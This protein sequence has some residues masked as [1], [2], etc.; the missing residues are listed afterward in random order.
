MKKQPIYLIL[1]AIFLV[2]IFIIFVNIYY[3]TLKKTIAIFGSVSKEI[4]SDFQ[5]KRELDFFISNIN[6]YKYN[7]IAPNTRNSGI[8]YILDNV[9][10]TDKKKF[11]TTYVDSFNTETNTSY[12]IITFDNA[13]EY[14]KYMITNSNYFIFLPGGV[15]T[16]YEISFVLLLID[17]H[18]AKTEMVIFYNRNNY[19][20]FV[21]ELMKRFN[22]TGYLRIDV[23]KRFLEK[24]HFVNSMEEVVSLL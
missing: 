21:K 18:E 11:T 14:E 15:G 1:L 12:H 19:F 24:T 13:I 22:D 6:T 20:N 17:L 10:E 5:F 8:G 16:L 2:V 3:R 9:R 7:Y 23:Y 4:S